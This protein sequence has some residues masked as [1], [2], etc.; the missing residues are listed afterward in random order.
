MTE[1]RKK[2]WLRRKKERLVE[3][4]GGKCNTCGNEN[5]EDLQFA[6]RVGFRL[7][8]GRSRGKEKRLLEV[9]R[10][11]EMFILLCQNCHVLYDRNN[12]PTAEEET[13]RKKEEKDDCP[14]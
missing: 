2:R 6:H 7:N 14:F 10:N 13:A 1:S 12:K 9:E 5:K 3:E 4:F 11:K 8:W